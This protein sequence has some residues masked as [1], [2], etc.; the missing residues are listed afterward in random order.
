M[1]LACHQ[2]ARGSHKVAILK[3]F[4]QQVDTARGCHDD[5]SSIFSLAIPMA[6]WKEQNDCVLASASVLARAP[7]P[8]TIIRR[9]QR[10]KRRG[11]LGSNSEPA[12]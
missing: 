9:R 11:R 10:R 2:H 8:T 1:P 5:L 3:H 6:I 12:Q 7:V 4:L